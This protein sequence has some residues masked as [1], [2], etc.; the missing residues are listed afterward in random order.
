MQK[1]D[2]NDL[3]EKLNKGSITTEELAL[4]ENWY[5]QWKQENPD[6]SLEDIELAK[7]DVWNALPLHKETYKT[8][9]NLWP[10]MA[11]A[12]AVFLFFSIG[13]YFI[14]HKQPIRQNAQI[15]KIMPGGNRAILTLS[16]GHTIDLS[17][18]KNGKLANQGTIA[19]DKNAD[20]QIV[21]NNS[22][23]YSATLNSGLNTATTPRGGQF[24]LVLADG[25]KVWLNAASSITF[26]VAF[27]GNERRV[28]LHGEAYFEVAHD[29]Q[30]PF[31]VVSNGQEV[32]V[33][34]TH[35]NINAYSDEKAIKTTLLE[36]SVKIS[37]A[38][39][40]KMLK[41]GEQS[42]VG[43][44]NIRIADVDVND[45][46]AWK[47]GLFEF[48]DDDIKDIMRQLGRW[49]DVDIKYKGDLPGREFSGE[50]PRNVNLSQVLDILS[51]EKIHFKVDGKT[52]TVMP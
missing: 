26:P 17:N 36:G 14:G 21:Y 29:K 20:G 49:Y 2:I 16:N 37:S 7:E 47:N 30:K 32:E 50:I 41:P 45:V 38:G 23:D 25:T 33:L 22:T 6:L 8:T 35:F 18:A 11:A 4:L 42:Q 34:G 5:L 12:V 10:L 19:I 46:V 43:S 3:L 9:R 24:Q 28:E 31:R 48:K 39:I 40:N 15:H 52:I 1:I 51:F 44:G 13:A 27:N